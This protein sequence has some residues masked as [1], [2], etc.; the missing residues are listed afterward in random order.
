MQACSHQRH[1]CN[2]SNALMINTRY[3]LA[4]DFA[5]DAKAASVATIAA[6]SEAHEANQ[7][8]RSLVDGSTF[9]AGRAI[10]RMAPQTQPR[11]HRAH[12][13]HLTS[14]RLGLCPFAASSIRVVAS[15][16]VSSRPVTS[17]RRRKCRANSTRLRPSPSGL[18]S[19]DFA[20]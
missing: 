19:G 9:C 18:E 15:R 17:S 14:I 12:L 11:S 3:T 6:F 13:S 7:T 2:L 16:H 8:Y 4:S 1:V 20:T 5:E 10:A